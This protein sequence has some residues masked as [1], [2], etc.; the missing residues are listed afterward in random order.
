M[1]SSSTGTALTFEDAEARAFAGC[2]ELLK[3][4]N[5][6]PRQRVMAYLGKRYN[7]EIPWPTAS[8]EAA[9]ERQAEGETT[10]ELLSRSAQGQ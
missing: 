1:F 6:I 8:E 10:T 2:L 4:L 5:K 7:I 3:P 9:F